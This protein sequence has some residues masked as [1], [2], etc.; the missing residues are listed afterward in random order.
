MIFSC[1]KLKASQ[2][3][4]DTTDRQRIKSAIAVPLLDSI[5]TESLQKN[6]SICSSEV[7]IKILKTSLDRINSSL[8]EIN[9]ARGVESRVRYKTNKSAGLIAALQYS[10]DTIDEYN[11]EKESLALL[12]HYYTSNCFLCCCR[13]GANSEETTIDDDITFLRKKVTDRLLVL[14]K[15]LY[16]HSL[17]EYSSE[18]IEHKSDHVEQK[19]ER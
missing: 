11:Q 14:D 18:I 7:K 3:V 6:Q 10:S 2:R 12:M 4:S 17:P 15:S 19:I 1:Y 8:H 9:R 16:K 5:L 13:Q